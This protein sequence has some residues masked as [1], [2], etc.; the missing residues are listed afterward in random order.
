MEA[1]HDRQPHIRVEVHPI[2]N[3]FFGGN[4]SVAGLVTGQDLIAQ[5]QGK[6]KSRVLGIPEV[7]LREER[8]RFLDD[9]TVEQVEKALKVKVRI[10]PQNGEEMLRELIR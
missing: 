5:L 7:M 2:Q 8:D 6:L 3:D 1:L 10:I 4:V 9:I